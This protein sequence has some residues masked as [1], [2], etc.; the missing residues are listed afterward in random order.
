MLKRIADAVRGFLERVVGGAERR[1]PQALLDDAKEQ[2]RGQ[3][4]ALRR[5]LAETAGSAAKLRGEAERAESGSADLAGRIQAE[6]AAGNGAAAGDLAVRRE[7]LVSEAADKRTRLAAAEKAYAETEA[8]VPELEAEF[9]RRTEELERRLAEVKLRETLASVGSVSADV[10]EQAQ[11]VAATLRRVDEV[12][13][14]RAAAAEGAMRAAEALSSPASAPASAPAGPS[15]PR[16][17]Q[18]AQ[19]LAR[20]LAARDAR[21]GAAAAPAPPVAPSDR[22]ASDAAG[23]DKTIGPAA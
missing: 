2:F 4:A 9:R 13:R 1:H 7:A 22:P 3:M 8:R 11:E 5:S 15:A 23:A 18:A 14:E 17:E 20:F 21:P 10:D 12:L 16:S 19:A 6:A